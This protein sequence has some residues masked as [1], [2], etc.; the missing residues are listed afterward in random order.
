[1]A[2][3]K[4]VLLLFCG[5]T[6][7]FPEKVAIQAVHKKEDIRP[8]LKNVGEMKMICE[9]EPYFI[10]GGEATDVGAREWIKIAEVISKNYKKYDGFVITHGIETLPYTA[11]A[12]SFMLQNLGKPVILT[13]SP[14]P[15]QEESSAE[16][17]QSIFKN[18][19]GLGVKANLINACQVAISDIAGLLVVFGSRII[20]GA[21]MEKFSDFSPNYPEMSGQKIIGKIDF[22]L[23]LYDPTLK[24]LAKKPKVTAKVDP[25]VTIF[26][27]HPGIDFSLLKNILDSHPH[28][29]IIKTQSSSFFPESVY[30]LLKAALKKGLPIVIYATGGFRRVKAEEFIYIDQMSL[31]TTVVKLMWIL[32]QTKNLSR[33]KKMMLNDYTGER[34]GGARS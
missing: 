16:I 25:K 7:L 13:G 15:S 14:I 1:M 18:F 29:L 12:L 27:F 8:W 2:G 32:G 17:L 26:D 31:V 23:T 4:K 22:G 10:F 20:V 28:G 33:I 21:Q 3:R 9:V 30:K 19:R 6:T 34:K 5:G 24:R 11:A